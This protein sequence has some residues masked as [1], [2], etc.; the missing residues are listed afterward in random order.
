ML[1]SKIRILGVYVLIIMMMTWPWV[2]HL[3]EAW[4]GYLNVDALDTIALQGLYQE[5][6][7]SDE[8]RLFWPVGYDVNVLLPNRLDHLSMML[9]AWLP[10]P[11]QSSLWWITILLLN[12]LCAHRLG[13]LLEPKYGGW[14]IGVSFLLS[15]ALTRE[16]NL[17]HAPQAMMFWFPLFYYELMCI[18]EGKK[19]TYFLAALWL[20]GASYTYWYFGLFLI[21]SGL[22]FVWRCPKKPQLYGT[23]FFLLLVMP[24]MWEILSSRPQI[25]HLN[26]PQG[27]LLLENS[28][29]LSF[30]WI[31]QPPHKSALVSF[32]LILA[33]LKSSRNKHPKLLW[34]VVGGAYIF[35]VGF[36]DQVAHV[37]LPLPMLWLRELHPFLARFHW[38]IRC[39]VVLFWGLVMLAV[40]VPSSWKWLIFMVIEL[41]VRS[42]NLPLV[43]TQIDKK[44]CV[45]ELAEYPGTWLELPFAQANFSAIHQRIHRQPL[46]N[47]LVL[48][49][50]ISPPHR[51]LGNHDLHKNI[52]AA[53]KGLSFDPQR[54]FNE[55]IVGIYIVH[56]RPSLIQGKQLQQLK[57]GI[58]KTLGKGTHRSCMS[59]WLL[60]SDK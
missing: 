49:P 16:V 19:H 32:V 33:A 39:D 25:L 53:E 55:G 46:I 20:A 11:L 23:G 50:N 52:R 51:W 29:G 54:L 31:S 22:P 17:H 27:K 9:F 4:I 10:F 58:A 38:P 40:R 7:F 14:F 37:E 56:T 1:L 35:T 47:P 21:L 15:T 13:T 8:A 48:P 44:Y 2:F 18:R 41:S 42:T 3:S 5:S 24:G 59:Y 30:M 36:K 34:C 60:K 57:K 12:A 43:F 45:A 26:A 28:P 6:W